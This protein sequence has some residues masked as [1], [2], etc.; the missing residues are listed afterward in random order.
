MPATHPDRHLPLDGT[1]NVRDVGGYPAANGRRIRWRTLLRSDELTRLPAHAREEL[2]ELGIRHVIDLRWPDELVT[3]PNTF[4]DDP[5]VRYT[6][7]PL[8]ADDPSPHVGLDGMYRHV[9]DERAPQLVEV[10]RALLEPGGMPAIIGCAAGKD[11]TGVTIA[12]LLDLAGVPHDVIVEDYAM[13]AG[14]FASPDARIPA[15]DWRHPP[16]VLDSP[17]E[18]MASTLRHLDR[19]HGGARALLGKRGVAESDLD[20]LVDRLTEPAGS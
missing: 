20:D 7:I 9:L 1:R 18:F 3:S 17:P 8:L 19:E 13:S 10:V 12:L 11:R 16:L 4:R 14:Y 2:H 5:A 15:G 6:S